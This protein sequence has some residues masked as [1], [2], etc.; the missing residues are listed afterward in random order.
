MATERTPEVGWTSIDGVRVPYVIRNSRKFVSVRLLEETLLANYQHVSDDEL[1]RRAPLVSFF[2]TPPEA[3]ALNGATCGGYSEHDLIVQL[4]DFVQFYSEVKARYGQLSNG[5][6]SWIQLNSTVMPYIVADGRRQVPLSVVRHAAKLLQGLVVES[7]SA[8]ADE[9]QQLT[10]MCEKANIPFHFSDSTQLVSINVVV[11][12]SDTKVT[13]F[14]LPGENPLAHAYYEYV[15]ESSEPPVPLL[16]S[17]LVSVDRT[18]QTTPAAPAADRVN[19]C[20]PLKMQYPALGQMLSQG[21]PPGHTV[22]PGSRAGPLTNTE[23]RSLIAGEPAHEPLR[24]NSKPG[25]VNAHKHSSPVF[26]L[27]SPNVVVVPATRQLGSPDG[28][29]LESYPRSLPPADQRVATMPAN[30]TRPSSAGTPTVQWSGGCLPY[31]KD[32]LVRKI[33]III[34]LCLST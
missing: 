8:T 30:A 22:P 33:I 31:R 6:C 23:S 15:V 20:P 21:T 14:D 9:R 28:A 18:M 34:I 12:Q 19:L 4:A 27:Q 5:S 17:S 2:M 24:T 32:M 7:R 1:R 26:G 13:V 10:A 16:S 3:R 25:R 11:A 29:V